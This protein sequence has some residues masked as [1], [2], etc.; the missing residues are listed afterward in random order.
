MRDY[1]AA[2]EQY[3]SDVLDGTQP[4]CELTKNAIRRQ[5][6][7]LADPEFPYR[8]DH[9]RACDICAFTERMKHIKGKWAGKFIELE[10]WQVWLL[11]T[12]FGWVDDAGNRR[13]KKAYSEIAR[14]N[15]K[16]SITSAIGN[17]MAFVDREGGAECY[18]A[19]TTRDQ[20]RIVF[21]DAR[22][23]VQKN[24]EFREAYGVE[25][26][27]NSIACEDTASFFKAISAEGSTLD[28]LNVHFASIDE[29]HAHKTP[30]V[31][32]V[33]DTA[34]G[35]RDQPLIWCITTAGSNRA[36]VCFQQRAYIKRVLDN[37]VTDDEYFGIIYTVDDED[38]ETDVR[39]LLF[40]DENLWRKANPN[41]GVSVNPG[42]I[43][44]KA[45]QASK[46]ASQQN[47]FLTK[48][49]DVWVNAGTA[50]LKMPQWDACGEPD[51]SI[52]DFIGE[53]ARIGLD[54]A[55]RDD[56][57]ALMVTFDRDG[58]R[59]VFGDYY[60]PQHAVDNSPNQ[61]QFE[62]WV[63]DGYLHVC[64]DAVLDFDFIEKRLLEVCSLFTVMSVSYDPHQATQLAV[65]MNKQGVPMRECRQ[66]R[67]VFNEPMREIEGRVS[68]KN[69]THDGNPLLAWMIANVV[70]SID[71]GERVYPYKEA[72]ENKIDGPVAM[73]MSERAWI[74]DAEEVQPESVYE[75]RG[76]RTL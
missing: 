47:N 52:D 73:I 11:S 76:L 8:F 27:A 57:A 69:L 16:S 50:W 31:Y 19:A 28:G 64:G 40:E 24:P 15:A 62:G 34:T 71:A 38:L 25:V 10:N 7:D 6:R 14:K 55:T 61:E 17:Y 75:S 12:V 56:M 67:T 74:D 26:F 3:Q 22:R 42:D 20:A 49:L 39:H 51:L 2:A 44:R 36:G 21:N 46:L 59:Y 33:I 5:V 37:T 29:L 68:D 54:L 65:N 45:R 63:T 70:A 72:P 1:I 13:F 23:M 43:K 66:N 4:A 30:A 60:L 32:D 58:K 41:Y 18:S 48:H 53:P 9:E 35:A